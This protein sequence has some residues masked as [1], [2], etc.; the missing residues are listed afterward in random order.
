MSKLW[1][2]LLTAALLCGCSS[3]ITVGDAFIPC[4]TDEQGNLYI[5]TH[6]DRYREIR[7]DG[8]FFD[9]DKQAKF[10]VYPARNRPD[11]AMW[12]SE[13]TDISKLHTI[14]GTVFR[15]RH[16]LT[17]VEPKVLK[18]FAERWFEPMPYSRQ[19]R[20][21]QEV[22]ECTFKGQP[23]VRGV[24]S[25]YEAARQ[26]YMYETVYIFPDPRQKEKFLYVVAW[27]ERGKEKD[28]RSEAVRE[29]GEEFFRRFRLN[30]PD[31][32]SK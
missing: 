31:P 10:R 11:L 22:V 2:G 25:S 28:C 15:K 14:Y 7:Y 29:Q 4:Q 9:W 32:P 23:A 27:S 26:L 1:F 16:D 17:S 8:F 19:K 18:A 3:A 5:H 12:L 13:L 21:S 30:E 24:W 20:L 6:S